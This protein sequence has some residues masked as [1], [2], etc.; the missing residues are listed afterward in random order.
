MWIQGKP[1][2]KDMVIL[3]QASREEGA[4]TIP[5]GSTAKWLEAH[6]SV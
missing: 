2:S 6:D 3:S 1:K 5:Y 4:T